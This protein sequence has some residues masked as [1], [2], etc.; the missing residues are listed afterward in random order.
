MLDKVDHMIEFPE[1]YSFSQIKKMRG[2]LEYFVAGMAG[3]LSKLKE[4][5]GMVNNLINQCMVKIMI[6]STFCEE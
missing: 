2:E 3:N 5:S 6:L 1:Q 4:N